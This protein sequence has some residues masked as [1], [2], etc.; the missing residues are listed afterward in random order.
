MAQHGYLREGYGMWG[1]HD[2]DF[3]RSRERGS[4]SRGDDRGFMFGERERFRPGDEDEWFGRRRGGEHRMSRYGPEHGFGGFQGDF[5]GG[6]EQGGFGGAG[7]YARGRTS[8]TS[9]PD[10][11]YRSWRQRQIEALDRDYADYCR[12]REQQFHQDFETWR[13]KRRQGNRQD[14][15][16]GAME[17]TNPIASGEL[18]SAPDPTATATLGTDNS[19]NSRSGR[20]RR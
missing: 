2:D 17:L 19:E 7:D 11:H 1:D 3:D 16:S 5:T 6:R 12:E 10:D 9:H 14:S 4:R 13:S 8:F 18:Q 20:A 15:D